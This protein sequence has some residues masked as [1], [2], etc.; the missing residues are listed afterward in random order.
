MKK[1]ILFKDLIFEASNYLVLHS[2][3]KPA[4]Y[5]YKR[6]WMQFEQYAK[7]REVTFYTSELG[8]KFFVKISGPI[9]DDKLNKI[10]RYIYRAL[11]VLD[12]IF[13]DREV[14]KRYF[15]NPIWIPI[16]Y[17]KYLEQYKKNLEKMLMVTLHGEI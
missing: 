15:Y 7:E 4:E 6:I 13:Y 8:N 10:Q 17:N 9:I 14:K 5:H 3:S 16:K 12:D 2:Y 1:S 11:K